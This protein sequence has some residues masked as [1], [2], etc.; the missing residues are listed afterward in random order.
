MVRHSVAQPDPAT[1]FATAERCWILES[2]NDPDDPIVSIARARV[3]VGITTQLHRL[4]D[5]VERYVIV[6]G[7]GEVH[8][9]EMPPQMVGPGAVV[10]IP[11]GVAQRIRNT[12]EGDLIFYC[13]CS[14]RF[15]PDCYENLE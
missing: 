11:A 10:V 14:P 8:V 6:K 13:V 3:E 7:S 2:W 4:R 15:E 9:G 12:G 1:E 5:V